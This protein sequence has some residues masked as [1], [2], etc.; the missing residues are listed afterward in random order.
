M[1]FV[2]D[3]VLR[4]C[5]F[6]MGVSPRRMNAEVPAANRVPTQIDSADLFVVSSMNPGVSE[7]RLYSIPHVRRAHRVGVGDRGFLLLHHGHKWIDGGLLLRREGLVLEEL[8]CQRF[9]AVVIADRNQ[10]CLEGVLTAAFDLCRQR[11]SIGSW[12]PVKVSRTFMARTLL[13]RH[14]NT[15]CRWAQLEFT[16]RP[17]CIHPGPSKA[18]SAVCT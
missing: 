13:R 2:V 16:V 10:E 15:S 7:S 8:N 18:V 17:G 3:A 4:V 12:K 14:I 11:G 6:W 5:R 9:L 1:P